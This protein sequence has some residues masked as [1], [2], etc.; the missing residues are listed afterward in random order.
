MLTKIVI[1]KIKN[2][3]I[4]FPYSN[5]LT[6]KFKPGINCIIGPNA[7]GKTTLLKSISYNDSFE[8]GRT[9]VYYPADVENEYYCNVYFNEAI[10]NNNIFWYDPSEYAKYN[11]NTIDSA[12]R[13]QLYSKALN[14]TMFRRSE[15]ECSAMYYQDWI[16]KNRVKLSQKSIILIDEIENSNSVDTLKTIM[17]VFKSLCNNNPSL[18]ILI[19]THSLVVLTYADNVIELKPN[20]LKSQCDLYTEIIKQLS[21]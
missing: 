4:Y 21:V 14:L 6:F 11:R 5:K 20:Y 3:A 19:A 9:K 13:N 12:M 16:S 10:I 15:A 8:P 1:P 2:K 18:Q 7:S 17:Y